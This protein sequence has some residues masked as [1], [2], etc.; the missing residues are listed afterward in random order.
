[1]QQ[2]MDLVERNSYAHARALLM[3]MNAVDVALVLEELPL[4]TSLILFRI[5]PKDTAA[6]V[7]SYM[8]HDQQ[9]TRGGKHN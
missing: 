3:D 5:L 4:E 6:S 7:F 1:M 8:S 9:K 2:I